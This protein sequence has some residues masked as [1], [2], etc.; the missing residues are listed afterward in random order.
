[1]KTVK[2]IFAT[3]IVMMNIQFAQAQFQNVSVNSMTNEFKTQILLAAMAIE[4]EGFTIADTYTT[5]ISEGTS[6]SVT[7]KLYSGKAYKIVAI[8]EDG[9]R[10]LDLKVTDLNGRT[11]VKDE[12]EGDEGIAVVDK[13]M[14]DTVYTKIRVKNYD[15]YNS[16]ADYNTVIIVAYK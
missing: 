11:L 3:L 8:G 2:M 9:M 1:M 4:A 14:W 7:R 5:Q 15:S 10:D 12:R 6:D 16:L 13:F